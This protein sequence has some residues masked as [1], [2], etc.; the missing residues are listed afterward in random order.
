MKGQIT[1][2]E[3]VGKFDNLKRCIHCMATMFIQKND[4]FY[5]QKG[6]M[7]AQKEEPPCITRKIEANGK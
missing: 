3:W 6:H 7:F 5:W 2:H 4:T 1:K